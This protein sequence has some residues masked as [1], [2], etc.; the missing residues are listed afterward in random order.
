M[1]TIRMPSGVAAMISI[2]KPHTDNIF[3]KKKGIEWRTKPLPLGKY[4]CYESKS[5]GGIGKVIGDFLVWRV[6]KF[7]NVDTIPEFYIDL[8]C[9]SREHLKTYSAGK[10]LYANSLAFARRFAK[11]KELNEFVHAS[12][13]DV[14]WYEKPIKQIKKPPQSYCFVYWRKK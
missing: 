5:K 11:P 9:V 2:R 14:K 10:P 13:K 12:A 6:E 1:R 3:I 7:D 4:F 8:G